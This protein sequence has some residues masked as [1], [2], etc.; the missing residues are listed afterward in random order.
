MNTR[1]RPFDG[2]DFFFYG[3]KICISDVFPKF[4]YSTFKQQLVHELQ[5]F[6][7][8]RLTVVEDNGHV[9]WEE[10]ETTWLEQ[11]I[12]TYL[13]K[14]DYK[15]RQNIE[16]SKDVELKKN[17]ALFRI[18]YSENETTSKVELYGDHSICDA[19]S[20]LNMYQ[21]IRNIIPNEPKEELVDCKLSGFGQKER[22]TLTDEQYE[23]E[24]KNWDMCVP[25]GLLPKTEKCYAANQYFIYDYKPIKKYC[26][27]HKI[28][29]HAMLMVS[30]SRAM[31]KYHHIDM[32]ERITVYTPYDTRANPYATPEFKQRQFLCSTSVICPYDI[33]YDNYEDELKECVKNLKETALSTEGPFFVIREA[34]FVNSKT[35]E[36]KPLRTAPKGNKYHVVEATHVGYC[37]NFHDPRIRIHCP[38]IEDENIPYLMIVEAYHT[39]DKLYC[40]FAR[41]EKLD[42]KLIQLYEEEIT[43]IIQY[44]TNN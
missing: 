14:V 29:V 36:F 24:P 15:E 2:Y 42:P 30:L 40:T 23:V 13:F 34:N 19:R 33:G 39:D 44:V 6:S 20:I 38:L 1:I 37:K 4:D 31:R 32:K 17:G 26:K 9:Y 22:Y 28:S 8:F 35:L 5:K 18:E 43:A 21:V 7:P 3:G 16:G 41:P 27:E 12:D 25:G 10:H 11:N